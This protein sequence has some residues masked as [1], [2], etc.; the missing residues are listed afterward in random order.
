[1]KR[2]YLL[3]ICE[4]M[5]LRDLSALLDEVTRALTTPQPSG[6]VTKVVTVSYGLTTRQRQGFLLLRLFGPAPTGLM[7]QLEEDEAITDFVFIRAAGEANPKPQAAT[8][9]SAP[10]FVGQP[11]GEAAQE[12]PSGY[13]A[14]AAAHP[15]ISVDDVRWIV[16][17]HANFEQGALG[18]GDGMLIFDQRV[19]PQPLLFLIAEETT[20][21][22]GHLLEW[23]PYFLSLCSARYQTQHAEQIKQ[24]EACVQAYQGSTTGHLAPERDQEAPQQIEEYEKRQ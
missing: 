23:A 24:I 4:S 6:A 10:E 13:E 20:T 21:I 11:H 19:E 5:S 22:F 12:L 15:L 14:L 8:Q 16:P 2:D 17:A 3:M 9:R 18:E 7:H 1:M